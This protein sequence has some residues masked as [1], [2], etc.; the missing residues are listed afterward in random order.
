MRQKMNRKMKSGLTKTPVFLYS[1]RVPADLIFPL[2][3]T[4][5][6]AS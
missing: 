5:S 3:A 2:P 6:P 1:K 4:K